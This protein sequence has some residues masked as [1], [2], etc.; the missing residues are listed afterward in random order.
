[1]EALLASAARV[2]DLVP[3]G[4]N[5]SSPLAVSLSLVAELHE[6]RID[7]AATNRVRWGTQLVLV[8]TLSHFLELGT[9]VELL[10]SGRNVDLTENQVNALWTQGRL[11]SDSLASYVLPLVACGSPNGA[12]VE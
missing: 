5:W 4:A 12:G 10:R 3:D 11:A 6:G 1:M 8:A 2:R 7:T 9:E